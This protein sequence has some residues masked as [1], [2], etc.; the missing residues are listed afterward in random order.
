[1]KVTKATERRQFCY[2]KHS[3]S[4]V[5]NIAYAG[6]VRVIRRDKRPNVKQSRENPTCLCQRGENQEP[7]GIL[8]AEM[9]LTAS[10]APFDLDERSKSEHVAEIPAGLRA[11][12]PDKYPRLLTFT[13]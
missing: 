3:T 7:E 1:M 9:V 8:D 5:K 2:Q 10:N 11:N 13:M 6:C 12:P 4:L